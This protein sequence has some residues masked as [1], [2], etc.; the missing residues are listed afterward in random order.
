[1]RALLIAM[2]VAVSAGACGRTMLEPYY[3]PNF[4]SSPIVV[5]AGLDLPRDVPPDMPPDVPPDLKPDLPL[6]HPPDARPDV[7]TCVPRGAE[8]CNGVDDDC[9]GAVDDGLPAIPC[10]EGGERLCVGGNYS[11]CPRRC[12]VC[13]PGS[14][15]TCIT[16]FCTY[17]GNQSCASDGRSWGACRETEAPEACREVANRMMRSPELEKCCIDKGFCCVD[18]F[19]LNNNGDRTE[20]LGRCESVVCD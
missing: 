16:S 12:E 20:M 7:V 6:E 9:N 17:W 11:D 8:M 10:P 3:P 19:D 14:K 15:R 13:V 2:G 4:D 18:E 1:V 5:D